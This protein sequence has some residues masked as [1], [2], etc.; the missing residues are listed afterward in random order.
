VLVLYLP[1]KV[2]NKKPMSRPTIVISIIV[3]AVTA[4]VIIWAMIWSPISWGFRGA[5]N[6][7]E[8]WVAPGKYIETSRGSFC[9]YKKQRFP[10]PAPEIETF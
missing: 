4:V 9:E 3:L 10:L 1:A 7:R 6:A 8:C 5:R 2:F